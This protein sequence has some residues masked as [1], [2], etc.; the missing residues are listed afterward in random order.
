MFNMENKS[1]LV[2]QIQCTARP[3][4]YY[5]QAALQAA[6]DDFEGSTSPHGIFKV[7]KSERQLVVATLHV[8]T[9]LCDDEK[10]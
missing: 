2:R 7:S 9:S 4:S 8:D 6:L 10:R 3:R 5:L 1:L